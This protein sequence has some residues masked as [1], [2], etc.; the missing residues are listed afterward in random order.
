MRY[1]MK[2]LFKRRFWKQDDCLVGMEIFYR[3]ITAKTDKI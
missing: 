1:L 3:D 2:D